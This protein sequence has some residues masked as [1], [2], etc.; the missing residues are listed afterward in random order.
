[1]SNETSDDEKEVGNDY[2][3]DELPSFINEGRRKAQERALK[4]MKSSKYRPTLHAS[5]FSCICEQTNSQAKIITTD[6][7]KHMDQSSLELLSVAQP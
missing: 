3:D 1:M 7:R 5:P 2:E 4:K 6:M